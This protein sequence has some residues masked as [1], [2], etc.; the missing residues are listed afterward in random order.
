M[1]GTGPQSTTPFCDIATASGWLNEWLRTYALPLWWRAGADHARGGFHESLSAHGAALDLP[2]RV[3][4]QAR[5]IYVFARVGVCGWP[6]PWREAIR[7][8]VDFLLEKYQRYDGRFRTLVSADGALLDDS[9][10]LYDQAFVLLALAALHRAQPGFADAERRANLLRDALQDCRHAVGGFREVNPNPFQ[11]N[12]HMHLL[13]SALAWIEAGGGSV[14]HELAAEIV[15]LALQ[16]FVDAEGGFIREFFDEHWQPMR[17]TRGRRV[18]PGHQ[19]EWA[20]LL[21]RW[22]RNGH[23]AAGAAAE[24]LFN[25]GLRGIDPRRGV[26][27]D[28]MDDDFRLVETSA[29]LWPQ[30]EYLKAALI[31]GNDVGRT[32]IVPAAL[33]LARYFDTPTM[34]VWRD[35]MHDD[36]T[37]LDGA[38]PASSLYHIVSAITEFNEDTSNS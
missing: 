22:G 18:E 13:E 19:F 5:Q 28:A 20:G 12:A 3:R 4:V 9:A 7:H 24:R 2:R 30:A 27:V 16:R 8:G 21:Q 31:L 11:S 10:T 17:C 25:A 26:V 14:W 34:G 32:H 35:T 38:A 29:R 23:A 37:F 36:G 15:D 1:R 6:G 33:T